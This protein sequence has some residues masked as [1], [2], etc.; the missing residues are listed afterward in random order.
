MQFIKV[1]EKDFDEVFTQM[2]ES[3]PVCERRPYSEAKE[4]LG[5]KGYT[6]FHIAYGGQKI[7]FISVWELNGFYFIEHFAIYS[8]HRNNGYGAKAL[9]LAKQRFKTLVL[10]VEPP[11]SRLSARRLDF[12]KRNGFC[13]NPFEYFQPAYREGEDDVRLVVL[14]Y[15]NLVEEKSV[16]KEIYKRVYGR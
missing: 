16:V 13:E 7:G 2:E 4:V 6:L 1:E 12:Y 8:E 3:F 9:D 11:I 14:S 10:E 5:E 15:P